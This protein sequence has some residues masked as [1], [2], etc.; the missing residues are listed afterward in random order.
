MRRLK[1]F[2]LA[3][4]A[5]MGTG[6]LH[7]APILSLQPRALITPDSYEQILADWTREDRLYDGLESKLFV[8]ATFHS[9]EFRK[10]FLLRH[11]DVYG[12]GSETARRLALTLPDAVEE[13]EFFFSAFTSDIKWNDF[14]QEDSIWRVILQGTN[15]EAVDGQV[16]RIKTTANLRAI[17]PFVTDFARTYVVRFP[18]T[19][20]GGRPVISS[21]SHEI[22]L[23]FLSALGGAKLIWKLKPIAGSAQ[24]EEEEAGE[25]LVHH[26]PGSP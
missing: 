20:A 17:Y 15:S 9:P 18:R 10:N 14:D 2:A 11:P 19:D 12:R 22:G 24:G 26:F 25:V 21:A 7:H 1:S 23:Q 8:H 3:L 4:F 5:V 16:S 13:I 6:C